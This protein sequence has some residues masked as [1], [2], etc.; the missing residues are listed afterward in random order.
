MSIY[1]TKKE[2]RERRHKRL[3]QKVSGTAGCP[4]LSVCCTSKHFYAQFIDDETSN[5]LASVSSM[6]PKFIK[7]GLKANVEGAVTLGKLAAEKAT[8]ANITKVVFD[9]G[10]FKYHGKVKAF[11]DSLRSGG[12]TF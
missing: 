4:R 10:G 6:D 3:R 9:R 2:K 7:E 11:A 12:V 1:K 5:T 8:E